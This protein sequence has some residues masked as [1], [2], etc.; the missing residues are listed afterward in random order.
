M[1]VWWFVEFAKSIIGELVV[2]LDN[3]AT[4]VL[5][6]FSAFNF[7]SFFLLFGLMTVSINLLVC[8]SGCV[9]TYSILA[10]QV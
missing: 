7:L 6:P 2:G 4:L 3:L 8:A 5:F 1:R 10:A 9:N